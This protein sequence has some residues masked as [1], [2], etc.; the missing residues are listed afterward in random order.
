MLPLP[1]PGRQGAATM[2]CLRKCSPI[3]THR[4]SPKPSLP[5]A[6]L[7][8]LQSPPLPVLLPEAL[9]TPLPNGKRLMPVFGKMQKPPI[10]KPPKPLPNRPERCVMPHRMPS[11]ISWTLPPSPRRRSGLHPPKR[12]L[13]LRG[14]LPLPARHRK[15]AL[16]LLHLNRT[17]Q[18]ILIWTV[19]S[20]N[21]NKVSY[22]L[23]WMKN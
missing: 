17:F 21:S 20:M 3:K 2:P 9:K 19:F 12:L 16:P 4:H 23:S 14:S 8:L 22:D 5:D 1:V 10:G 13:L 7:L 15:R 18:M 11:L 6:A